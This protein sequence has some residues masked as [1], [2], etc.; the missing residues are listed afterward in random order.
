MQKLQITSLFADKHRHSVYA[1]LSVIRKVCS[2]CIICLLQSATKY[3]GDFDRRGAVNEPT[4]QVHLGANIPRL[5][6]IHFYSLAVY[7][8]RRNT[9]R[10]N[11]TKN[12]S[13]NVGH[14]HKRT[15][16]G[17]VRLARSKPF[18]VATARWAYKVSWAV[19]VRGELRSKVVD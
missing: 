16:V 18:T 14:A 19:S 1:D 4:T 10:A 11:D 12:T 2:G 5:P 8:W 9:T 13:S 15:H 17:S 3:L 7:S 6:I